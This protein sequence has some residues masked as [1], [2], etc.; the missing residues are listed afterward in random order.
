[1]QAGSNDSS[2]VIV[3]NSYFGASLSYEYYEVYSCWSTF[4]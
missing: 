2:Q 3:A 4:C 1:M